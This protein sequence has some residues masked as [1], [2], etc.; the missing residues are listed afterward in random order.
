MNR[1]N[2]QRGSSFYALQEEHLFYEVSSPV[3]QIKPYKISQ[4]QGFIFSPFDHTD[5]P[6]YH[7][8]GQPQLTI[9]ENHQFSDLPENPFPDLE[10][11]TRD[12][13]QKMYDE[14]IRRLK[15]GE[16]NKIVLSIREVEDKN[17]QIGKAHV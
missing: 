3:S 9:L 6:I 8:S 13:Y 14:G 1:N 12:K 5:L 4:Q 16:I 7:I 11:V 10:P 15:N 17:L 2:I